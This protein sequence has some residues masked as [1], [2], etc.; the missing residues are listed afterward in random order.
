MPINFIY[1]GIPFAV[2][3]ATPAD[4]EDFAYGFSLTEGIIG[5]PDEIR[6]LRIE[7]AERG[8]LCS[9]ELTA[10]RLHGHLARKRAMAGRTGCG[11]CG[12]D[13]LASLPAARSPQ[14]SGR[15]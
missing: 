3:M 15:G 2:M 12:I 4:I 14:G 6:G 7:A 11:L 9:L 8:L 10:E 5:R 13:D 1:G